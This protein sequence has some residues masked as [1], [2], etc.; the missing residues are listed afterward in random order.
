M[1]R[2][3]KR[4]SRQT[5]TEEYLEKFHKLIH[6]VED[7]FAIGDTDYEQLVASMGVVEKELNHN[8]G[9]NWRNEEYVEYLDAIRDILLQEVRFNPEQLTKAR[10]S[11]EDIIAWGKKAEEA[12]EKAEEAQDCE[13][14]DPETE[15]RLDEAV[16]F[17]VARV[18]DWCR[19][20]PRLETDV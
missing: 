1:L 6:E 18:V 8:G 20:N 4:Q 2:F 19:L 13:H 10:Q 3:F 7:Q 15:A 12:Q 9:I 16:D 17:L 11:L 14:V 5:S